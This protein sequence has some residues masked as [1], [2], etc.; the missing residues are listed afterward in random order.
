MIH[1]YTENIEEKKSRNLLAKKLKE[2]YQ[3]ACQSK[4]TYPLT[5]VLDQFDNDHVNLAEQRLGPE[6]W[7]ILAIVILV[8][9]FAYL[10]F[11]VID[12]LYSIILNVL[13]DFDLI[14]LSC[15]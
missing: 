13:V 15:C 11:S 1:G 10:R 2:K 8:R 4:G 7:K 6:H 14:V 12:D 5:A 9:T 3:R